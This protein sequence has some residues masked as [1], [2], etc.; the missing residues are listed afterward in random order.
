MKVR[1]LIKRP[2]LRSCNFFLVGF[3]CFG[4]VMEKLARWDSSRVKVILVQGNSM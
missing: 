3:I 2:N 4:I 1:K